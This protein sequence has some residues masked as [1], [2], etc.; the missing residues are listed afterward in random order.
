MKNTKKIFFTL[1][2]ILSFFLLCMFALSIFGIVS[3][4]RHARGDLSQIIPPLIIIPLIFLIILAVICL[5][6]RFVFSDAKQR[7][8]DPWL[9][10]TIAIFIP[11]LMGLIIYLIVRNSYTKKIC[12]NCGKPLAEH[13]MNCPF[14]GYKLKETCP[15]CGEPVAPEWNICSKCGNKLK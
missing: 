12:P 15:A 9:W 3:D 11:N 5:A 14:C 10:T 1:L 7:G 2:T 6:G 8:M 13:F 4:Y